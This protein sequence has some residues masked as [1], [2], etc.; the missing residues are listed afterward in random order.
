MPTPD[1]AVL[2]PI[3]RSTK[4]V[5]REKSTKNISSTDAADRNTTM[6]TNI[7]VV[8]ASKFQLMYICTIH[9][10]HITWFTIPITLNQSKIVNT[11][12]FFVLH[13]QKQRYQVCKESKLNV[14]NDM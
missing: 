2:P 4:H 3:I 8:R 1:V 14:F 6:R 9:Y 5:A 11:S 12:M 7:C 10:S 13:Y